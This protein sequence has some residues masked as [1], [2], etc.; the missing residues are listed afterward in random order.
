M[1]TLFNRQIIVNLSSLRSREELRNA[2]EQGIQLSRT[3]SVGTFT[4]NK[5]SVSLNKD[6]SGLSINTG[7]IVITN[8]DKRAAQGAFSNIRQPRNIIYSIQA[9][10][11][12]DNEDLGVSLPLLSVGVVTY[13]NWTHQ[14]GDTNF[15]LQVNE[16]V[17][18]NVNRFRSIGIKS[19]PKGG[20]VMHF[21]GLLEDSDISI[22]FIPDRETV[23]KKILDKGGVFE[24][25]YIIKNSPLETLNS[26]LGRSGFSFYIE[27]GQIVVH[28]T[29]GDVNF[30]QPFAG[31]TTLLNFQTGLLSADVEVTLNPRYS[32]H[33]PV[34]KFKSLF[35]PE[36]RP[37]NHLEINEPA[38]PDLKGRYLI[39]NV[40]YN[41]TNKSGGEFSV[42][43]TALNTDF[44][45]RTR[46]L[47]EVFSGAGVAR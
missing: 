5:I 46:F 18:F 42:S 11:N 8:F 12:P 10:Y 38:Y 4:E 27:D 9:G 23:A 41:L 40:S 43:G 32:I 26:L 30:L 39:E 35:I 29:Q 19:I 44:I 6:I 1:G 17:K 14:G 24:A 22:R 36:I 3:L 13:T 16:G 2:A 31:K 37:K 33:T 25:D 47:R 45:Q 15:Q 7:S 34:L 21:L 28:E 20:T